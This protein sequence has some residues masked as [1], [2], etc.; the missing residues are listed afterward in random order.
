MSGRFTSLMSIVLLATPLAA[1]AQT[2]SSPGPHATSQADQPGAAQSTQP[3]GIPDAVR[4][5]MPAPGASA[6]N[7]G[8]AGATASGSEAGA[9]SDAEISKKWDGL[10]STGGATGTGE[11][12]ATTASDPASQKR[13]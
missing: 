7:S 4:G 12:N 10:G 2:S 9:S 3:P 6:G 8:T 1:L 11:G 5:N 13:Q